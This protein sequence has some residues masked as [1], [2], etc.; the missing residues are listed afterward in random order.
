MK[1]DVLKTRTIKIGCCILLAFAVQSAITPTLRADDVDESKVYKVQ[2]AYLYNF[3]KFITWPDNVFQDDSDPFVI[4]VLDNEEFADILRT[5][6][7]QKKIADRNIVVQHYHW[8]N[9]EDRN[10]LK[11]C[12]MIYISQSSQS[13]LKNIFNHL[14]GS[15]QLLV[16]DYPNFAREGGMIGFV[17]EDGRIVFEMNR[18]AIENATLHASSKLLKLARIVWGNG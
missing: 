13:D 9:R 8:K 7:R 17:L 6:I 1:I 3:A 12:Q 10:A 4:G 14:R 2:A 11:H 16:G 15:P 5:T 18:E